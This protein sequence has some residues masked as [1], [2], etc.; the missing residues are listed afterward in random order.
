MQEDLDFFVDIGNEFKY[1]G[2]ST[3]SYERAMEAAMR[4]VDLV[5]NSNY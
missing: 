2:T 5:Y 3:I 1:Y 4:S